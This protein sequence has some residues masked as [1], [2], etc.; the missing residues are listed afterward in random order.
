MRELVLDHRVLPQ[1]RAS[2]GRLNLFA[3]A[4]QDCV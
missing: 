4:R 3:P 2:R 1:R